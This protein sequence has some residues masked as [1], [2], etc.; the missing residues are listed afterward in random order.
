MNKLLQRIKAKKAI[1]PIELSLSNIEIKIPFTA[2]CL[3][4]MKI[5]K[6]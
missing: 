1:F 2:V 3:I 5:G 6:N 4:S